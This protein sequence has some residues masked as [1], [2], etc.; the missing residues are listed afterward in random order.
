MSTYF[1]F[2]FGMMCETLPTPLHIS[3]LV[4]NSLVMDQCTNLVWFPCRRE[5]LVELIVLNMVEV[6][7]IFRMDC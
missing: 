4:E 1:S 6:D 3:I 5:N 2:G 7:V